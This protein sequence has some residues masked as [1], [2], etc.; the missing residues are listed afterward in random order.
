[1]YMV[2]LKSR[3]NH[4]VDEGYAITNHP[5]GK[6]KSFTSKKLSLKEKYDKALNYLNE[7]NII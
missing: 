4:Y 3:P 5:N 2:Y 7:L 6:N 1:M